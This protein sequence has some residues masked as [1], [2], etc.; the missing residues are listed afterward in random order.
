MT[1]LACCQH[2]RAPLDVPGITIDEAAAQI[3]WRGKAVRFGRSE[4]RIIAMMRR[5]PGRYVSRGELIEFLFGD[6]PDGGPEW[7]SH[8]IAV[9]MHRIRARLKGAPIAVESCK[10][11]GYRLV[12]IG[13]AANGDQP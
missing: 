2:C 9:R 13:E 1:S 8:G 4:M 6:D 7:V 3:V 11:K 10:G 12:V 5:H